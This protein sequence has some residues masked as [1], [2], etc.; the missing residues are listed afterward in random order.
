MAVKKASEQ[1]STFTENN[2]FQ[3]LHGTK[4][5]IKVGCASKIQTAEKVLN[6][7]YF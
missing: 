3:L 4:T 6:E 1:S 2:I 5:F 7:C